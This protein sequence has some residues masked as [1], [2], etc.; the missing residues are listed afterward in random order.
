MLIPIDG[1]IHEYNLVHIF[2][3]THLP[4]LYHGYTMVIP[5]LYHGYT[6][7]I[8]WLNPWCNPPGA[9]RGGRRS[10]SKD[11][12]LGWGLLQRRW[13]RGTLRRWCIYL[14]SSMCI[15]I[16]IFFYRYRCIY[17]YIHIYVIICIYIYLY[18][19]IGVYTCI[20]TAWYTSIDDNTDI[21]VSIFRR[22]ERDFCMMRFLKME[23]PQNHSFQH[24]NS[25][26][27]DG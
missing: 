24:C 23:D 9:A 20:Y 19:Y 14:C 8:S 16:Y 27:L 6:M 26:I 12:A 21:D 22:T 10:A 17:I 25:L 7:V 1:S 18:L 2:M 3:Q 13:R 5:W 4:W 11:G 15:Y